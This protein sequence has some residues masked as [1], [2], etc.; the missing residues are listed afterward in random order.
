MKAGFRVPRQLSSVS[1]GSLCSVRSGREVTARSNSGLKPFS[2]DPRSRDAGPDLSGVAS[3]PPPLIVTQKAFAN[4]LT[5]ARGCVGIRYLDNGPDCLRSMNGR[6][7]L[8][9]D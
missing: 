5:P 4:R 8:K 1:Q 9:E 6:A 7:I 3:E 2:V